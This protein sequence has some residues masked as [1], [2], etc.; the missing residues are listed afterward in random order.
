M[1]SE[2]DGLKKVWFDE[3]LLPVAANWRPP[4]DG[5]TRQSAATPAKIKEGLEHSRFGTRNSDFGLAQPGLSANAF[6]SDGAQEPA[7]SHGGL[8]PWRASPL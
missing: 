1:I 8:L 5:G 3:W 4:E 6:G 2:K 7:A